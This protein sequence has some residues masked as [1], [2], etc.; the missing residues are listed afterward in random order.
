MATDVYIARMARA[1]VDYSAEIKEKDKVLIQGTALAA[2]LIEALYK[3]LIIKGA[4]PETLLI[5][6]NIETIFFTYAQDHQLTYVSP[7]RKYYVENVDIIIGIIAD[8]NTKY[9]ASVPPEK[10]A[11]RAKANQEINNILFERTFQGQMK[12]T[13]TLFPT[14]ALAQEASMSLMEYEEFVHNACFLDKEDPVAAWKDL[15]KNQEKVVS[16]LQGKSTLHFLGEDTDLTVNVN[17]RTWINSDGH[18][19]FPSGEVFTSPVET[20]AE[21]SIRFTYPG[22]YMG[23]EVEDITLTFEKGRVVKASAEKGDDLLQEMLNTDEGAR[24]LGEVAIGTNYGI[25]QFTKNILFDEKIGGTIHL[26][27]GRSLPD[28]GGQND[29]AIHWDLVKNMKQDS[30]IY[31]DG[32]LF[33]ENGAFVF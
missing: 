8:Y 26:A 14:H 28:A 5:L 29:S 23:K 25:T 22:I 27:V 17:G 9:L 24:R 13:L 19:N 15:S 16:Y 20:S 33:Y 4:Y 6:D 7:F 30:Q 31:A 11:Q 32:E 12:W 1:L 3:E 21:G 10:I 18:R 2:P